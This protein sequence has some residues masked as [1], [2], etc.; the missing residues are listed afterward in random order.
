[1]GALPA[2]ATRGT[3]RR[4]PWIAVGIVAALAAYHLL[5]PAAGDQALGMLYGRRLR[6]GA[7]IYGEVWDIRQPLTFYWYAT[8]GSILG[9]SVVWLR[10]GEFLWQGALAWL[11]AH[12]V[13]RMTGDRRRGVVTAL[14]AVAPLF[15]LMRPNDVAQPDTL[16][17]LPIYLAFRYVV[18]PGRRPLDR[19]AALILG[20]GTV[21][22]A[23]LKLPYAPLP[24]LFLAT[25]VVV[26]R[27]PWREVARGVGWYALGL[28][29]AAGLVVAFFAQQGEWGWVA[30]T[31]FAQG[32]AMRRLSP[33]PLSRLLSTGGRV[34]VL[35]APVVI[36]AAIGLARLRRAPRDAWNTAAAAWLL[37]AALALLA[38]QWWSYQALALLVP[39]GLLAG[40]PLSR[41]LRGGRRWLAAAAIVCGLAVASDPS[42]A[43]A[44]LR[45]GT[46]RAA[47][48]RERGEGVNDRDDAKAFLAAP[49]RLRGDVYVFGNPVILDGLGRSQRISI[50][51]WSPE[52]YD[53]TTWARLTDELAAKPP[54]YIFIDGFSER[55]VRKRASELWGWIGQR[56]VREGSLPGGIAIFRRSS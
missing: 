45:H 8:V 44:L 49:G 3:A 31:W 7:A 30:H 27:P 12:D 42:Y 46:D 39:L 22:I 10:I 17:A 5:E 15:W 54:A 48:A 11:I 13:E 36:A 19:R 52:F 43:R 16:A 26:H 51:G 18:A 6:D 53:D 34:A 40:E 35:A 2:V 50:H 21:G 41:V 24:F 4:G 14:A 47:I 33:P 1:M 28:A 32:P 9:S 56:Y 20:L 37:G 29:V 55:L 38:Q 25:W 23:L